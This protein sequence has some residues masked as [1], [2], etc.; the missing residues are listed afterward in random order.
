M[1]DFE[2][3]CK[4]L[5]SA[6]EVVNN[7][8]IDFSAIKEYALG[9]RNKYF[10]DCEKENYYICGYRHGEL[11]TMVLPIL[12]TAGVAVANYSIAKLEGR[13]GRRLIKGANLIEEILSTIPAST[14][15]QFHINA[16]RYA[17]YDE[18]FDVA[19]VKLN[20]L[21]EYVR[22]FKK[23]TD[24]NGN[25]IS[26]KESYWFMRKKDIVKSDGSFLTPSEMKNK[27]AL[28][29]APTHYTKIQPPSNTQA[30]RG[31]AK[32]HVQLGWGEGG[33]IQFEFN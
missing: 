6:G 33:G 13:L 5:I 19:L 23:T 15:N 11:T 17:P 7:F 31:I 27:F 4:K 22:V 8:E 28:P 30:Y 14:R 26:N 20:S 21:E 24:M 29:E 1:I 25:I 32:E 10:T 3:L 18:A 9:F 2:K 16:G 12:F